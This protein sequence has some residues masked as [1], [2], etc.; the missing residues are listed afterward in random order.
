[1]NTKEILQI[2]KKN[3]GSIS[4]KDYRAL[5]TTG[6]SNKSKQ[7]EISKKSE[8]KSPVIK[9]N[10]YPFVFNLEV[11]K[12]NQN[13]YKF[14]LIGRHYS[15]N[16]VNGWLSF[17]KRNAYKLAVKKA[18]EQYFLINRK[19]KPKFPFEKA[20]MYSVSYNPSSRDDDGNRITLKPFR[21]MLTFNGFIKDDK[22][23]YFFE[24]PNF[25]VLSKQYKTEIILIKKDKL[26]VID[27]FTDLLK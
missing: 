24:F 1:M 22:R 21:D 26:P 10:K 25:E 2:A 20:I 3:G 6:T 17:G 23:E 14:S 19:D 5:M 11:T 18:F 12:V 16:D 15:T 13:E 7:T 8:L 27:D 9:E 4:A